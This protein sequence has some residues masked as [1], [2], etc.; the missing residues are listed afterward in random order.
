MAQAI[1][2]CIMPGNWS[3]QTHDRTYVA[4]QDP[5]SQFLKN[6]CGGARLGVQA[7]CRL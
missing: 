1:E 3:E 2:E 6:N 7:F 4:M 5:E